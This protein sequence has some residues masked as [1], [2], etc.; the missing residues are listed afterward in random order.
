M[1]FQNNAGTGFTDRALES[2]GFGDDPGGHGVTV[3][4][5]TRWRLDM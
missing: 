4:T 5:S 2:P 1:L 3:A